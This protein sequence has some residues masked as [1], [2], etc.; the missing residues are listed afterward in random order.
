MK[1]LI[2]F[3]ALAVSS[4]AAFAQT[5]DW[6]TTN[7]D[8]DAPDIGVVT[9]N[10]LN[11]D[12]VT[13]VLTS[14]T[15]I[16]VNTR[17]VQNLLN[18]IAQQ[19]GGVLYFPAGTYYL[20]K[21]S[22][23][24]GV[25]I[26]GDWKTP[27]EGKSVDGTI[28]ACKW[29]KGMLNIGEAF[30][31]ME[32][33]T[34]VSNVVI[35]YPDQESGNVL[36]F[37][38]TIVFGKSGYWGNEY[39]HVRNVT[40]VNSYHAVLHNGGNGGGAT[41]VHN[42]YGTI[43]NRGIEIDN[44]SE[45]CRFDYVHW[46]PKYWAES[47]LTGAPA[48]ATSGA[49]V[50]FM[51]NN[52]I[53]VEMK[54]NDW[55]YTTFLEAE[56]LKIGF[57]AVKSTYAEGGN[58][59]TPNGH[60]YGFIFK[61][62]GTGVQCDDISSYGI[63]FTDVTTENC[64][65]GLVVNS[66][67]N[68]PVQ[69]S[70]C[71]F[72]ADT[73]VLLAKSARSRLMMYQTTVNSGRVVIQNSDFTTVDGDYNN[74]KPQIELAKDCRAIITGNRFSQGEGIKNG[75]FNECN[76][77]HTPIE[78]LKTPPT[79]TWEDCFDVPTKPAKNNLF[80]VTNAPY[81]ARPFR[82]LPYNTY[83]LISNPFAP[84]LSKTTTISD[85]SPANR[86][87]IRE[88]Y[89]EVMNAAQDATSNIQA[90]LDAAAS[91]GGG[92]VYLPAGHYK[93]SGHLTIPAGVELK[94]AN[95]VG[96][97]PMGIGTVLLAFADKNNINGKPFITMAA[98]S[99]I[100]GITV[101]YPEQDAFETENYKHTYPYTV[102][103]NANTYI[104]NLALHAAYQGVDLFTEK[105]DNHFIDYLAGQ[106][107]KNTVRV[108][109]GSTGGRIYNIQTNLI[110][111]VSG[112]ENKFGT[113]I[114]SPLRDG[115]D[116]TNTIKK[117]VSYYLADN[118]DFFILGDCSDQIL[119]NN[120]GYKTKY[121]IW[122]KN[123]G[124][125]PSGKSLG[126]GIDAGIISLYYEKLGTG[127]FDMVSSQIVVVNDGSNTANSTYIE[128]A[129][130]F[131]GEAN[132]FSSDY[133]GNPNAAGII[134][135]GGTLNLYTAHSNAQLKKLQIEGG[136]VN[137]INS[138]IG[139]LSINS[140]AANA[141]NVG[142]CYSMV[143]MASGTTENSYAKWIYNLDP[144]TKNPSENPPIKDRTGWIAYASENDGDEAQKSIDNSV[145]TYWISEKKQSSNQ[146][147][148]VDM[149]EQNKFDIIYIS[150]GTSNNYI[151]RFDVLISDDGKDWTTIAAG[152]S[153]SK[154]IVLELSD[155][156]EA[157]YIKIQSTSSSANKWSIYDFGIAEKEGLANNILNNYADNSKASAFY[158]NGTL[159]I[160]GIENGEYQLALYNIAGQQIINKTA[161]S[162][163]VEIDKLKTGIY[164][165]T[166]K[167]NDKFFS[168]KFFAK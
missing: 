80:V 9:Y 129:S 59:P 118:H 75:S 124:A 19:G 116:Q 46:S 10:A 66:S 168:G 8:Y 43:F 127:G 82:V 108:G 40:F 93:V 81:N 16:N 60:N 37:P 94:G 77:D 133:W 160:F 56:Y 114:N 91:N 39:C 35:W 79:F 95:D 140:A 89:L 149:R 163:I 52:A 162:N 7:P 34:S 161:T 100:R 54:R 148:Y 131:T 106:P 111:Y 4:I 84:E 158:E 3:F 113:W 101:D 123:E 14:V 107:F 32:P 141:A 142:V 145:T 62:C 136:K 1:K 152:V 88:A 68:A 25:S 72:A 29:G 55:S 98:N 76:I 64:Q 71:T 57:H 112:N 18:A 126:Q 90:A 92:I 67:D 83:T 86:R 30:I 87:L 33:S 61:N 15:D 49:Y 165:L 154:Q 153:G 119:Y 69:I 97:H 58:Y 24:K 26:R 132:L 73:A 105:C 137:L 121:G 74:A 109:S 41:N 63:M 117:N 6:T 164:V 85:N 130:T 139:N 146:W 21:L 135:R 27:T 23:P 31:T 65:R 28:L 143:R 151:N 115:G 128:T 36:K 96:T 147:Y 78:G 20:A 70:N 11:H 166:I 159:Q 13:G 120:F 134:V 51:K 138:N 103:G 99:G 53:G 45:V 47:G 17:A 44:V 5:P 157:Q 38:P 48:S 22:I 42:V 122:F 155:T 167:Q 102:R 125:G 110:S 2:V 156:Y 144:T 50:D 150:S 12:I 104:V